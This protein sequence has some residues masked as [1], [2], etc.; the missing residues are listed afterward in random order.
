[1][2]LI[3][4]KTGTNYET[5]SINNL[6]LF[7]SLGRYELCYCGNSG[8]RQDADT[9]M[10]AGASMSDP[11]FSVGEAVMLRSRDFPQENIDFTVV[12]D[13]APKGEAYKG[14]L[15]GE[16]F[17]F[18]AEWNYYLLS[19]NEMWRSE[20]DL[21]PIPKEEPNG[22]DAFEFIQSLKGVEA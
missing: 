15:G 20:P 21:R 3:G 2:G 5:N 7:Y 19:H 13:F 18:I 22:I 1:M 11:K 4:T 16:E 10:Q 6:H 8:V 14:V 12:M 9:A 17:H